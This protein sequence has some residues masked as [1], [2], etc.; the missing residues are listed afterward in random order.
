MAKTNGTSVAAI[1]INHDGGLVSCGPGSLQTKGSFR[2]GATGDNA[3]GC[4]QT[5]NTTT[6]ALEFTFS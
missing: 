2:V 5:Y 4:K 3:G 1:Y 6:Q